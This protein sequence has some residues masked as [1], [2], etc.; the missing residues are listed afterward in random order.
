M[1]DLEAVD[2]ASTGKQTI[3]QISNPFNIHGERKY[4][5]KLSTSKYYS[6]YWTRLY[7]SRHISKGN[8]SGLSGWSPSVVE[9]RSR[10]A[11]IREH[12]SLRL[13]DGKRA[14]PYAHRCSYQP[15]ESL[16]AR[17]MGVE[18]TQHISLKRT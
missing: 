8:L 5:G 17:K 7:S 18:I 11:A 15:K 16:S 2:S 12:P 10:I 6:D 14:D 9:L 4:S 3:S 13:P 1:K